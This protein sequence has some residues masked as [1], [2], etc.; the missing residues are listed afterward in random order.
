MLQADT[1]ALR[2][3]WCLYLE[4][5]IA[6]ALRTTSSN[7]VLLH[8]DTILCKLLL[9]CRQEKLK[10]QDIDFLVLL[11]FSLQLVIWSLFHHMILDL[12]H[13]LH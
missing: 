1:E 12:K 10:S 7:K 2:K 11:R 6:R 3:K 5:A 4:S 13:H 8:F 9:Y